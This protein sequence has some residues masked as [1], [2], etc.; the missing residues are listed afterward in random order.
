MESPGLP[1]LLFYISSRNEV[2][3]KSRRGVCDSEDLMFLFFFL[4]RV[5]FYYYISGDLE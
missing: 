4:I 1:S 2:G 3:L 5:I